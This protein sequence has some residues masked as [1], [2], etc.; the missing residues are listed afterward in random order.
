MSQQIR[1]DIFADPVCPWCLIGKAELD[2]ALES[3]PDHPFAI[4]WQPFRLDPQ[5][6]R[7]GMDYV[8]YMKMKFTDEKGIIAAMKPV[9]EASERLGLWINPS[10]IE[11]MPN[12]LDAHRLLH[13]AGLEG[14][15]TPV[16]AALMRA[17]WREGRNISNPDVLVEIGE[18]AGMDGAVI[19]R[20]LASD[21]DRDTVQAREMHAR[22]RGVNS[23]PTFVV[24]DA[25]VVTGAQP[26]ALWLQVIDEL[27]GKQHQ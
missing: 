3:R 26:A 8:A 23:V 7:A 24:A 20:L 22:Q 19:R 12:T 18:G 15:Q 25:H 10:L 11:R 27:A 2:R 6:P 5:M 1:L 16:M 9:M 14:A 17:H 13:W 21:A 4:T